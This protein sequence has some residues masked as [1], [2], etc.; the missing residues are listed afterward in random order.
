M[1]MNETIIIGFSEKPSN[2]V[3]LTLLS[4]FLARVEYFYFTKYHKNRV[5]T[6]SRHTVME[7]FYSP[8]PIVFKSKWTAFTYSDRS[9]E[10]C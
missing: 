7:S 4:Y 5:A 6:T 10:E 8:L 9:D 3:L 2:P 1:Y